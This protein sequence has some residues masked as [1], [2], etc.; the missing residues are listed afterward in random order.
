[1]SDIH[2]QYELFIKLLEK[3]GFS[4]KD[5]MYVLG[6]M[7]DKGKGSIRLLKY[8]MGKPN[9]HCI[10]GNHEHSLLYEYNSIMEDSPSDFSEVL[11]TLQRR[12][13]PDDET[14][15][16]EMLDWLESLPYYAEGEDFIAVH[17]GVPADEK[18]NLIDPADALPEQLIYDRAFKKQDYIPKSEKCVIFGHTPTVYICGKPIILAYKKKGKTGKTIDDYYKIHIDTDT[19]ESK[20]LG[21]LC[22]E[23]L[24]VTYVKG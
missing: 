23:K 3:I 22:K 8:V 12:F 13:E 9:V 10:M 15:T 11:N 18:N 2:G 4:D 5:E 24:T 14:L 1:V 7:I 20:V 6:D 19:W 16:F 21:C 17:A